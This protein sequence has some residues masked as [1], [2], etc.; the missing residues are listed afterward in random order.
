[1]SEQDQKAHRLY[2]KFPAKNLLT[3]KK[4]CPLQHM[5]PV[6]DGHVGPQVLRFG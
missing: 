2:G 3:V 1:M 6:I 5:S 4:V